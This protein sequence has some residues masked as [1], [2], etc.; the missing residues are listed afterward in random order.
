MLVLLSL[1]LLLENKGEQVKV[2]NL[3]PLLTRAVRH[4]AM[5]PVTSCDRGKPIPTW[6]VLSALTP[7]AGFSHCSVQAAVS[8]GGCQG[9][10]PSLKTAS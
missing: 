9:V 6:D 4:T 7:E 5:S 1:F 3:S 8:R 10:N 2:G